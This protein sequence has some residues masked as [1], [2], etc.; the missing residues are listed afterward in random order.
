MGSRGRVR[1]RERVGG[2][3]AE[4]ILDE[5]AEMLIAEVM[6]DAEPGSDAGAAA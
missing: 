1:G 3:A 2:D 6:D 5:S 4:M